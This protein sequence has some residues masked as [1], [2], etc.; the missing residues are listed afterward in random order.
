MSLRAIFLLAIFVGSLPVCFFRPFYGILMWEVV[1]FLNPQSYVWVANDTFPWA[2]VI[3]VPTIAGY[4][5]FSRQRGAL[6]TR[7]CYLLLILWAWFTI[8]TV[9]SINDPAFQHHAEDTLFHWRFVSKV[10]L[11]V[12]FTFAIVN[13]FERLRIL[14]IVMSGCF[15]LFVLKDLPFIIT[16]GG[17]YHLYGPDHSMIADNNDFGLA[18]NMTL[19]MFFFLAQTEK[20]R[21][22]RWFY[23]FMG[24]IT[25]PAIFFTYSRGAL[26][27]LIAV[28]AIMLLRSKQRLILM[29]VIGLAVLGA[30]LFAPQGW[31]DRMDP[32]RPDA[33]DESARERL[34]SWAFARNL[35]ADYPITGGGF[36]TFT[37]PLFV[38]YAPRGNDLHGP[39][40]VY[41]QLL[42]EHG[43]PGL[44]LYLTL[45]GSCFYTAAR[46]LRM[47]RYYGDQLIAN[48][49]H[50][51][52]FSLLGFL[53]SGCFLGRAYFDYFF[54]IVACIATLAPIAHQRWA[55]M[56][57]T[58]HEEDDTDDA[59][60]TGPREGVIAWEN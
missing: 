25:I 33:V 32:T 29:P 22:V 60:S 55:D 20:K 42:A 11:M 36:A 13:T 9:A 45:L 41:F 26:V 46:L 47:A 14:V 50:M 24:I 38:K 57:T 48:Y 51:F 7:E 16:T 19:P 17:A 10:L 2:V 6:G 31:K 21:W 23:I 43:F 5:L 34:N 40:S 58:S 27:G 3:A 52:R 12:M 1:A 44:L 28:M 35:A 30:V 4:L 56:D 49:V 8:T 39:H 54:A 18:L 15:G 53:S 37:Q 59:A